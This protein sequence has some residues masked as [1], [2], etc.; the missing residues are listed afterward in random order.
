MQT[1][2]DLIPH[3]PITSELQQL[4]CVDKNNPTVLVKRGR[5]RIEIHVESPYSLMEILL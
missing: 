5:R 4:L 3:P 1:T 2:D